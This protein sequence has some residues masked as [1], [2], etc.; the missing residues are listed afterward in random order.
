MSRTLIRAALEGPL[1]TWAASQTPAI[2]VAYEGIPF[3]P[4]ANNARYLRGHLVP[5]ATQTLDIG[6]RHRRYA[7]LWQVSLYIPT[8]SGLAFAQQAEAELD[9]IYT[10]TTPLLSG[11]LR[12]WITQPMSAAAA[13]ATDDG[14][15]LIP[16]TCRWEAHV[17]T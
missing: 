12:L 5:V 3:K 2:P 13:V 11:S 15:L 16:I 9:S 4:P 14:L 8:G 10:T 17:T 7:G 6:M 1:A